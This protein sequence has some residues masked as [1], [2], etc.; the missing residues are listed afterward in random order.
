MIIENAFGV[1]EYGSIPQL[2]LSPK[3]VTNQML[4]VLKIQPL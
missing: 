4:K 1:G 2:L 3:L